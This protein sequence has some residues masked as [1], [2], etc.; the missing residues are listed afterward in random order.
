[1]N[2]LLLTRETP[3]AFSPES[4]EALA[5]RFDDLISGI[6][7]AHPLSRRKLSQAQALLAS[8]RNAEALGILKELYALHPQPLLLH[9]QALIASATHDWEAARNWLL[10]EQA[11]LPI[12]DAWSRAANAYQLGRLALQQD[13][14]L[15]AISILRTSIA[16]ARLAHD[17]Q[18]EGKARRLLGDLARQ[19]QQKAI[20]RDYYLTAQQAFARAGDTQAQAEIAK[21]MADWA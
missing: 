20:A 7:D 6:Q 19:R 18:G 9:W 8:Q 16:Q 4:S 13:R 12:Q 10:Q 15:E 11:S 1:M 5:E 2:N 14:P 21:I 17:D 3:I